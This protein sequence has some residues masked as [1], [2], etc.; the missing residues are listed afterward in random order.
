MNKIFCL[1]SIL[2]FSCSHISYRSTSS[3]PIRL[4]SNLK[5]ES[6]VEYQGRCHFFVWGSY[7]QVCKVEVDKIYR[8]LGLNSAYLTQIQ[9]P[10]TLYDWFFSLISFGM[11]LPKTYILQAVGPN[12][13]QSG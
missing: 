6:L 8:D 13:T 11:Y 12:T 5:E 9:E 3:I 10:V 2:L 4:S 7:P 1:I